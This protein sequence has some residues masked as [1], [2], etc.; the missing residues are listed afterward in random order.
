MKLA[1]VNRMRRRVL[2]EERVQSLGLRGE[3]G[4]GQRIRGEDWRSVRKMGVWQERRERGG[5]HVREV[6]GW[7]VLG[8]VL[9]HVKSLPPGVLWR[10]RL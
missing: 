1:H 5:E 6:R 8:C 3:R 7:E 9:L 10:M 2:A 4:I